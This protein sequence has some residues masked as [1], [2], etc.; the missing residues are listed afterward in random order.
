MIKA[1][2]F[3]T[4]LK[5][6]VDQFDQLIHGRLWLK[7]LIALALGVMFGVLL[8][9]DLNLVSPPLV[10]TITAWLALTW[11]SILGHYSNDRSAIGDGF[12]CERIGGK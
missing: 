7:V 9:P 8:G 3:M 2:P 10:K 6:L 4:P 1:K 5:N 12:Y 11:A